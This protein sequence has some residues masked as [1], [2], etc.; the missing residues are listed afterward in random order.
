MVRVNFQKLI[1]SKIKNREKKNTVE[2]SFHVGGQQNSSLLVS[3]PVKVLILFC[4]LSN[5]YIS[6]E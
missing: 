4:Q 3:H 6:V 5:T 2:R 1:G